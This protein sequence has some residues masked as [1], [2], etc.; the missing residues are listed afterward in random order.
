MD[1]YLQQWFKNKLLLQKQKLR[2][3]FISRGVNLYWDVL[4]LQK[5]ARKEHS[6]AAQVLFFDLVLTCCKK[7]SREI[8]VQLHN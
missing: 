5:Y 7:M 6:S 1:V 8:M 3:D 2:V 4:I